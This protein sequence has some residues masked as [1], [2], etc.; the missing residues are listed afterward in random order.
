MNAIAK[1]LMANL[2]GVIVVVTSTERHFAIISASYVVFT[3][4][5]FLSTVCAFAASV[6]AVFAPADSSFTSQT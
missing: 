4:T 3:I 2:S 5:V 6:F 1:M